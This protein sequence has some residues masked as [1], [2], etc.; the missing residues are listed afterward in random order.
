MRCQLLREYHFEAAHSLPRVPETHQCRRIHGH[1]YRVTVTIQGE[2]DPDMGWLM[3]FADID[4]HVDV[5]IAE[6]DHRLLND[7][8]GLANP[9]CENLAG[10]LWQRLKPGLPVL[11]ELVVSE[12]PTS[13]CVV[14][15][16]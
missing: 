12:T 8:P 9:T 10:W 15:G 6:L 13:R 1:S 16:E 11:V 5:L 2:V 7:I 3:D 14:R 4:R